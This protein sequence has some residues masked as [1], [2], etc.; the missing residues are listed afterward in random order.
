M[1]AGLLFFF[2]QTVNS[3]NHYTLGPLYFRKD[4]KYN[5]LFGHENIL[6]VFALRKDSIVNSPPS[7]YER[8]HKGPHSQPYNMDF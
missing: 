8:Q 1:W 4:C 3:V 6:F 5:V 2:S 7:R